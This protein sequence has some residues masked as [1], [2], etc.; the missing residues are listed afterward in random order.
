[1]FRCTPWLERVLF[2]V[3]T[4]ELAE[5]GE[6]L[7]VAVSGGIDSVALLRFCWSFAGSLELSCLLFISITSC[8]ARNRIPIKNSSRNWLANT[9]WSLLRQR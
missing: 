4:Q 5:A 9:H 3:R 8:V 1:M 6:R 2:H 7:G